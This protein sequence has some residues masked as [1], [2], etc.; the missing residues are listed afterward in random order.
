MYTPILENRIMGCHGNHAVLQS[1]NLKNLGNIF[2]SHSGSPTE[3]F[4]THEILP[5]WDAR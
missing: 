1:P 4:G 2:F 3:Q 5:W